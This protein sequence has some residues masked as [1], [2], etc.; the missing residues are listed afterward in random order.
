MVGMVPR[1]LTA[2]DLAVLPSELP[3]GPVLY[4][5]DDGRLILRGPNDYLHAAVELNIATEL[6][7]QGEHRGFGRASCGGVGVIL[8]RNPDRVVGAD[9]L[10]IAKSSLPA[11]VSPEDYLETTPDLAVEVRG[12][13]DT[14]LEVDHKVNDY[15][16]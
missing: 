13:F 1:L 3:S 14:Q 10:F 15:L 16:K 5:L 6:K 11:R 8:R 9:A 7:L 4:E 12:M 2:A